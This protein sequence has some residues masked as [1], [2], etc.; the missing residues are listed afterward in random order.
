[1]LGNLTITGGFSG[2]DK[3]SPTPLDEKITAVKVY[4]MPGR[5]L[6]TGGVTTF[7]PASASPGTP[8]QHTTVF[9]DVDFSIGANSIVVALVDDEGTENAGVTANFTVTDQGPAEATGLAVTFSPK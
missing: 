3:T 2:K 6:M 9:T 7:N 4:R 5:V 8:V 1:M